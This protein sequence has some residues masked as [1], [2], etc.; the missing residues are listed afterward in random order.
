MCRHWGCYLLGANRLWI[1]QTNNKCASGCYRHLNFRGAE[2]A[3]ENWVF[4]GR[5]KGCWGIH[6]HAF[7]Y[8][9]Y[10]PNT[11]IS[12]IYSI[13]VLFI[14]YCCLLECRYHLSVSLAPYVARDF[15]HFSTPL[16]SF[17][18]D[19]EWAQFMRS[20]PA[21]IQK[22]GEP[23]LTYPQWRKKITMLTTLWKKNTLF[24]LW[25][26]KTN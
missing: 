14:L 16:F 25:K 4:L 1:S 15:L 9:L 22:Q 26:I 3:E 23:S 20:A 10:I 18:P 11:I 13:F 5:K 12:F 2:N 21:G 17:L 7:C 24:I 8:L 19:P 6:A